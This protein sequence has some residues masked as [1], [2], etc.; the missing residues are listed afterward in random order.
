MACCAHAGPLQ[1]AERELFAARYKNAARMYAAILKAN[2]AESEAFSG[3]VRALIK[4]HRSGEAYAAAADALGKNPHTTGAQTAAGMAAFRRGEIGKAGE[5]F[6]AALQLDPAYAAALAG[7]ASVERSL[8]RFK[9][10]HDLLLAAYRSSPG[11]PQLMI[12]RANEL[13]GEERVS[14]L[15][16]AL[17]ILDPAS[18]EA[19]SLRARI[20]DDRVIGDRQLRRLTN[21][22]VGSKIKLF[23]GQNYLGVMVQLNGHEVKLKLD[24]GAPGLNLSSAA[25]SRAEL[26]TLG[27]LGVPALGVGGGRSP[28]ATLRLASQVRIGDL[29]FADYPVHVLGLAQLPDPDTDGYIG[30]DMFAAF[31]VT[32]DFPKLELSL[33]PYPDEGRDPESAGPRDAAAETPAGFYRVYRFGHFLA[34]PTSINGGRDT[35]FLIDCGAANNNMDSSVGHE[36]AKVRGGGG[37]VVRGIDGSVKVSRADGVSLAF[38]GF[39]KAGLSLLVLSYEGLSDKTG[40]G[41]GGVIGF[42]LLKEMVLTID[43]RQGAVRFEHPK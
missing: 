25:A 34:V 11:D 3:L 27:S 33:A 5:Y 39:R 28:S 31:L 38:A 1:D 42:R 43:Y 20:A 8:S 7:L 40:A 36:F 22:Y 15:Q 12:E 41:L 37:F 9:S 35:L 17:T 13:K 18:Q 4:D 26:E 21:P 32:I 19:V 16:E 30:T 24:S 29:V 23:P 6:R 2:P 14:A 10:A